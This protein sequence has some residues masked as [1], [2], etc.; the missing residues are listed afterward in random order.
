MRNSASL[1]KPPKAH[2]VIEFAL[3]LGGVLLAFAIMAAAL[4]ARAPPQ[5]ALTVAPTAH[6]ALSRA[7][8]IEYAADRLENAR[9]LANE[10]LVR[11]PFDSRALRVSG[12]II[13]RQG[14]TAR[15]RDILTL[16]GN[17][18]LRDDPAHAWLMEDALRR[19]NYSVAFAHADTLARRRRDVRERLFKFFE[20]SAASDARSIPALTALLVTNPPWRFD[21]MV[22]L[23]GQKKAGSA[24]AIVNLAARLQQTPHPLTDDELGLVYRTFQEDGQL[25]ALVATRLSLKR[26]ASTTTVVDGGFDSQSARPLPPFNWVINSGAGISSIVLDPDGRAGNPALTFRISTYVDAAMASQL[27]VASPGLRRLSWRQDAGSS[28][29][30]DWRLVWAVNCI[31][32]DQPLLVDPVLTVSPDNSGTIRYSATFRVP[33]T[34]CPAQWLR[35]K[36]QPGLRGGR[37]EGWIDDVVI[38]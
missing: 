21:F 34:G 1:I 37:A 32:S 18:S 31:G 17:L 15:A 24:Q 20:T 12:L 29:P 5:L 14:D 8:E 2:D 7:S 38:Q 36:L 25:G 10:A 13:A 30:V 23:L 28:G 27:V 6:S 11:A 4:A 19:G 26:P 3:I 9:D 16:A 33:A 22:F 35:L